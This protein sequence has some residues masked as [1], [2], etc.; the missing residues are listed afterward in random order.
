[1]RFFADDRNER[2][3]CCDR[4]SSNAVF[5]RETARQDKC[6]KRAQFVEV[7]APPKVP[8]IHAGVATRVDRFV[9]GVA[10]RK[11]DDGDRRGFGKI[12]H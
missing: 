7:L 4:A 11:H 10:P 3:L 5:V 8:R 9:F 1:L 12:R 6:L 2:A